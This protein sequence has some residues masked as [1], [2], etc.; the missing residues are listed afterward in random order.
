L[1]VDALKEP[2]LVGVALD[3]ADEDEPPE[4]LEDDPFEELEPLEESPPDWPELISAGGSSGGGGG[5]VETW[6]V[7]AVN[8]T[9]QIIN[10]FTRMVFCI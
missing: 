6:A 3:G 10:R 5:R 9:R 8:D 4:L 1:R 7:I 2:D